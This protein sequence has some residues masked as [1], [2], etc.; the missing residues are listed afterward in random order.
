M[1]FHLDDESFYNYTFLCRTGFIT[2][3]RA[4]SFPRLILPNSSGQFAKFRGS[5]R[6]SCPKFSADRGLPFVHKLSFILF[7]KL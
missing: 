5:P 3:S 6:Q 1:I 2:I 7:K 4:H